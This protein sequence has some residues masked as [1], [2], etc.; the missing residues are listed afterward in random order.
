MANL[1]VSVQTETKSHISPIK[2]KKRS[3]IFHLR[4]VCFCWQLLR[5]DTTFL[6][7]SCIT[8]KTAMEN[9]CLQANLPSLCPLRIPPTGFS[10]YPVQRHKWWSNHNVFSGRLVTLFSSRGCSTMAGEEACS[11]CFPFKKKCLLPSLLLQYH[12]SVG[13]PPT[14]SGGRQNVCKMNRVT[15]HDLDCFKYRVPMY[16][17]FPKK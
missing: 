14:P 10:S 15:S 2:R 16:V 1:V 11:T 7:G 5:R 9:V 17:G 12:P 8:K 3:F 4:L 6:Y 13:E